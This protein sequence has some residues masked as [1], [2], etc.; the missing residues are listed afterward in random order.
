MKLPKVQRPYYDKIT[1]GAVILAYVHSP[2]I[3]IALDRIEALLR[4]N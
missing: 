2:Q 1:T 4:Q 3:K